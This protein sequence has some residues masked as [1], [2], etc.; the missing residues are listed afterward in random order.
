MEPFLQHLTSRSFMVA[1][2][3]SLPFPLPTPV[4]LGKEG[5]TEASHCSKMGLKEIWHT[6]IAA[7]DFYQLHRNI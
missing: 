1:S 6:D 4:L 3:I 7:S 2:S 5:L